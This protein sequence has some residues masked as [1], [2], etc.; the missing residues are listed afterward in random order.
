MLRAVITNIVLNNAGVPV[1]R[2]LLAA[3]CLVFATSAEAFINLNIDEEFAQAGSWVIGYNNSMSGC[4]TRAVY[5]NSATSLSIVISKDKDKDIFYVAMGD[6]TRLNW[7]TPKKSYRVKVYFPDLRLAWDLE[8][9]A[10]S[11]DHSKGLMFR[12]NNK[13]LLDHLKVS[14]ELTTAYQGQPLFDLGLGGSSAAIDKLLECHAQ[15][16]NAP[17]PPPQDEAKKPKEKMFG[18]GTG[19]FVTYKY[20][21][22]NN[23]VVEQCGDAIQ[24]LNQDMW[25]PGGAAGKVVAQD[26]VNDLALITSNVQSNP[27][28]QL[29]IAPIPAVGESVW[30]YGFPL[31]TIL[32]TPNFTSGIIAATSG[33]GGNLG[34]LQITAPVQPGN[35]GSPLMD[36]FGNV[37]GVVVSKL[38]AGRINEQYGDIPQNINFAVKASV[39]MTF[40]NINGVESTV[41]SKSTPIDQTEIAKT[42]QSFTINIRCELKGES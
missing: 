16:N 39:A 28:S 20:V 3:T 6:T 35:S 2:I 18:Y 15:Y 34:Q 38:N 17:P 32:S 31:Q 7:L 4:L 40:M 30:V 5:D 8:V 9:L 37:V 19:F 12:S 21:M 1:K 27:F 24:L 42:A 33:M 23:H 22:T 29:R 26:K 36:K 13:L 11:G 41:A 10:I 14:N 25:G